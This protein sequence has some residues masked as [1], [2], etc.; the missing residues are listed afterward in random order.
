MTWA[1]DGSGVY[2]NTSMRGTANVWFAPLAGEPRAVTN[3]SHMLSMSSIDGRGRAVGT[4]SS[5]HEPPDLVSFDLN[6]P[7]AR[8]RLT[9]VNDDVLAGVT[10]GDVEEILVQIRG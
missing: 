8:R 7:T 10:L 6:D 3:G 5:Y 2:F 4:L 9:K 1:P